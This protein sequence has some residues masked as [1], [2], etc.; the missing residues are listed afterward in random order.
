MSVDLGT[1]LAIPIAIAAAASFGGAASLQHSAARRARDVGLGPPLLL[2]LL[3]QEGFVFSIGLG[4]LGFALQALA[5]RLG[6]L[7]LVQPLLITGTF[8]YILFISAR[9]RMR[10]DLTL[11]IGVAMAL[12]GLSAF[13]LIAQPSNGRDTFDTS[14]ALPLGLGLIAIVGGSLLLAT[15]LRGD[16]RVIPISVAAAVCY[17]V[18]AG[19]VRSLVTSFN[20]DVGALFSDWQL[21]AAM[22]VGPTGFMLNQQAF[23]KGLLGVFTVTII[24]VGDP[25]VSI[26]IGIAWLGESIRGGALCN[27]GEVVSLLVVAAGVMLVATRSQ[28]LTAE[29]HARDE[30]KRELKR[31]PRP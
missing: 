13:L 30:R 21:Y 11:I 9:M 18:M 10:P 8:F 19:L 2:E 14:A 16:A 1:A 15:W 23:Q 25:A 27:L 29:L 31:S 4:V 3:K 12:V 6:P 17:G 26:G 22:I 20:G 28:H 24:T 5:L 7:I